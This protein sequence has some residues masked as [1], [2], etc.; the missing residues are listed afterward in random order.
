MCDR[1]FRAFPTSLSRQN[2]TGRENGIEGR[3]LSPRNAV[4]D[5][6]ISDA[7]DFPV[8]GRLPSGRIRKNTEAPAEMELWKRKTKNEKGKKGERRDGSHPQV[9]VRPMARLQCKYMHLW[10]PWFIRPLLSCMAWTNSPLRATP[11]SINVFFSFDSGA[12]YAGDCPEV[13]KFWFRTQEKKTKPRIE[14]C[15]KIPLQQHFFGRHLLFFL[16]RRNFLFWE[17]KEIF[18]LPV[19]IGSFLKSFSVFELPTIFGSS[20]S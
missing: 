3:S 12:G 11:I 14:V 10:P 15:L 2:L 4:I 13:V 19:L 5:F 8:G 18:W 7:S 17:L 1:G 6:R 20:L 9:Q 16:L